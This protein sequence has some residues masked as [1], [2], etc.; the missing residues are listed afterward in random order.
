[1]ATDFSEFNNEVLDQEYLDKADM[2]S[3]DEYLLSPRNE[4]NNNEQSGVD[5]LEPPPLHRHSF[6]RGKSTE[7]GR[8]VLGSVLLST[9]DT[10]TLFEVE[11]LDF[12]ENL[13]PYTLRESH[14]EYM[15]IINY[16]VSAGILQQEDDFKIARRTL[17]IIIQAFHK[18]IAV[19]AETEREFEAKYTKQMNVESLRTVSTKDVN[20]LLQEA[21]GFEFSGQSPV[22]ERG[23]SVRSFPKISSLDLHILE[24]E[25][26]L[27]K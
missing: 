3:L 8:P 18:Y 7:R 24:L 20:V 4:K 17:A 21:E 12:A 9:D 25:V 26:K 27:K 14:V 6:S 23:S 1:M 10:E 13:D 11:S 15:K 16:F 5:Q 2:T 22:A 19:C